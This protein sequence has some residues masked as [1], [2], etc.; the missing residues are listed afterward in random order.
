MTGR[1]QQQAQMCSAEVEQVRHILATIPIE[2]SW[3]GQASQAAARQI[4]QFMDML[5][6]AHNQVQRVQS[7]AATA[8]AAVARAMR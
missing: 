8:D 6:A 3:T 4:Q 2:Q 1:F 5:T 7:A